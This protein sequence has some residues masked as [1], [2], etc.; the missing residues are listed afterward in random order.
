M[1]D[2]YMTSPV[3]QSR[4]QER[5]MARLQQEIDAL[6]DKM[7]AHV[8]LRRR[9][10]GINDAEQQRTQSVI[11][12]MNSRNT[13]LKEEIDRF[14]QE[15]SP[16]ASP[17]PNRVV[18]DVINQRT[19]EFSTQQH[20]KALQYK[21][22][23][24][25]KQRLQAAQDRL[26][27]KRLALHRLPT[28]EGKMTRR[29][30]GHKY[31]FYTPLRYNTYSQVYA[32]VPENGYYTY[33]PQEELWLLPERY[34][35]EDAL[36]GDE[37]GRVSRPVSM[38][39]AHS[40][41][42]L[43]H[44]AIQDMPHAV[45]R[46]W[47]LKE[48]IRYNYETKR[49]PYQGELGFDSYQPWQLEDYVWIRRFVEELLDD[50]VSKYIPPDYSY[51]EQDVKWALER[52]DEAEW[53]RTAGALSERKA[54]Q[55]VA[56]AIL[57]QETRSMMRQTAAEVIHVFGTFKNMTDLML[58]KEAEMISLG[59]ESG[60]E[61][62]DPAYTLITKSFFTAQQ[63]RNK[64]RRDV[65]THS[66]PLQ[67]SSSRPAKEDLD[68]LDTDVELIT[69]G[70]LHPSDL[71][72]FKPSRFDLP[73]ARKKKEC[74]VRYRKHEPE[75]WMG[76]EPRRMIVDLP[77]V[78]EGVQCMAPSPDELFILI[79]TVRG[80]ILLY[81]VRFEPWRLARVSAAS[82]RES[83]AVV[84]VGWSL[85][86][87]RVVAVTESGKLQLWE[88]DGPEFSRREAVSL[89]LD[90]DEHDNVARKMRR[91]A[92]LDAESDDLLFQQ[93]P[94]VESEVLTGKFNPVRGT[95]FP[96]F[97][98]FGMQHVVCGVLENGDIMKVNLETMSID[99]E[100]T[101]GEVTYPDVPLIYNANIYDKSHGVNLVGQNL[102]AELF[103]Q[104]QH[105]IMHLGYVDNIS[106]M[107][108]VD[109][110]GYIN[111][112]HYDPSY[113]SGFGYFIP[114]K[115]YKLDFNKKMY[116]PANTDKPRI[117]FTDSTKNNSKT[118]AQIAKE[119]NRVQNQLD[120]MNLGDPWHEETVAERNL[121]TLVYA[122]K[123]GVKDSGAMFNIVLHHENTL[124]LSTYLTRMYKPVKVKCSKLLG[125]VPTP[126]GRELVFILLFPEYPP[127]GAH[128]MILILDLVTMKLRDLRRD[129]H[130]TTADHDKL[131][132]QPVISFS[133]SRV[134]APTGA[135]YLFVLMKGRLRCVSLTTGNLVLRAEDPRR[136]TG[137]TGC[138]INEDMLTVAQTG[139]ITCVSC[140]GRIYAAVHDKG[141]TTVKVLKLTDQNEYE[142]RR[143][144]WKAYQIWDNSR[145]VAPETRVDKV[146][147]L[148][149]D[150]QHTEVDM[151]RL[152]L[153]L[154]DERVLGVREGAD[155][156][157][158]SRWAV[159]DKTEQYKAVMAEVEKMN[160]LETT[161]SEERH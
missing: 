112:W 117:I 99:V 63:N 152:I 102:E 122:P 65:W 160:L 11:D 47:Q 148:L 84:H 96:S 61:E 82:G 30:W 93:G 145:R 9:L 74:T 101:G 104:H 83:D 60:R 53:Q 6:E 110:N 109:D 43:M 71:Q 95:F 98:F 78:F 94:L 159:R 56:E 81:D 156:E 151:R 20:E 87:T 113:I 66:Q 91:V 92:E 103:R 158:D 136:P 153:D 42:S 58:M 100:T 35:D 5:K 106:R 157:G 12:K 154:V 13:V 21:Q 75:F 26:R 15:R 120:N 108:S 33:F 86:S 147:W 118:Q 123:G 52:T 72:K 135:E 25:E 48:D 28:P 24:A 69:F 39:S 90:S 134:L 161:D 143:L 55:L 29:Y 141:S 116:T 36:W 79:G 73:P 70:H 88:L 23:M 155:E 17:S 49:K 68:N 19:R 149:S 77:V 137:F 51:L 64:F 59:Q 138:A 127:K 1:G 50:F 67:L 80:D 85:D 128:I 131:V 54:V 89:G 144:M 124:Q 139:E 62:D 97:S 32:P 150:M 2:V 129:I 105:P 119:R 22:L 140:N 146:T 3:D 76:M 27:E 14:Y 10:E 130:L 41:A 7:E 16:L 31:D 46:I 40:N 126:S 38:E 111:F 37:R 34:P 18:S 125:V 4:L 8:S 114:E 57:L 115:K 133:T 121:V 132:E 45:H 142:G 107:V 44:R